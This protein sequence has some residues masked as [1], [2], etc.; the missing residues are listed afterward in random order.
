MISFYGNHVR[1]IDGEEFWIFD[2]GEIRRYIGNMEKQKA[3][4]QKIHE[5][6]IHRRYEY[7]YY[8]IRKEYYCLRMLEVIREEISK[9]EVYLQ[10]NRKKRSRSDIVITS[11]LFEIVDIDIMNCR[12]ETKYVLIAIDYFSRNLVAEVMDQKTPQNVIQAFKR[13]CKDE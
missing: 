5:E 9:C 4:V 8:E 6:L 7:I 13:W 10:I 2:R 1:V 3:M 12:A 11:R